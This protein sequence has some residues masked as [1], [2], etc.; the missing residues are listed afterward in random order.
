[1]E[2]YM[3]AR[4]RND[5]ESGVDTKS[6][7]V[8]LLCETQEGYQNMLQ[9]ATLAA[10][11]LGYGVHM[12]TEQAASMASKTVFNALHHRGI[13]LNDQQLERLDEYLRSEWEKR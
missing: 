8:T 11:I 10:V 2:G 9:L 13:D 1:M 4:T 12:M 6:Y 7:P 3:A 5:R